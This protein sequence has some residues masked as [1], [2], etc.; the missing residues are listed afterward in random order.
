[1]ARRRNIQH[2][3]A[4]TVLYNYCNNIKSI[5]D[6]KEYI[7]G[8]QLKSSSDFRSLEEL[9]CHVT[10]GEHL[11]P[12]QRI[13]EEMESDR[14]IK[15]LMRRIRA[16][17]DLIGQ[18]KTEDIELVKLKYF[19]RLAS[20]DISRLTNIKPNTIKQRRLPRI[21]NTACQTFKKYQTLYK[22]F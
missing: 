18:L 2:R 22:L 11:C 12:I 21:L 13:I 3:M 14:T 4:E 17:N 9:G 16:V 19:D 5:E 6:I 15:Y 10:G 7:R 1:M 20:Q 8:T